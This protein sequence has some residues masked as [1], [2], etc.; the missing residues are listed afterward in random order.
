MELVQDQGVWVD[1][2][3]LEA[4]V[5]D[6]VTVPDPAVLELWHGEFLQ[7]LEINAPPR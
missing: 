6:K 7:G 1:V 4:Q 5:S 2:L 3:E